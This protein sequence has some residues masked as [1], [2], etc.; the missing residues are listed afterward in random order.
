MIHGITASI[1]AAASGPTDTGWVI[2]ATFV[3]LSPGDVAWND[4]SNAG[5]D[6]ASLAVTG[7]IDE[8]ELSRYLKGTMGANAFSI[9][10]GATIDGLEVSID[11]EV[12]SGGAFETPTAGTRL[13]I[14]D[15]LTG[16][17]TTTGTFHADKTN[18]TLTEYFAGSSTQDWGGIA[19]SDANASTFGF[20]F[21]KEQPNNE[22][23]GVT[24]SVRLIKIKIYYTP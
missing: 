13:V 17:T 22:D 8:N 14:G 7:A 10:S 19:V 2:P 15:V 3:S 5:E 11:M 23:D 1:L 12:S 20:A 9:P 16:K 6:N 24:M 21:R 18:T 4:P